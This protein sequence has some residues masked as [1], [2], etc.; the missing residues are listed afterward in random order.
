MIV[1]IRSNTSRANTSSR[2][3][4]RST[5]LPPPPR[6]AKFVKASNTRAAQSSNTASATARLPAATTSTPAAST[7]RTQ[8]PGRTLIGKAREQAT[9]IASTAADFISNVA[10][11]SVKTLKSSLKSLKNLKQYA[12]KGR[13]SVRTAISQNKL[14]GRVAGGLGIGIDAARIAASNDRTRTAIQVGAGRACGVV[15][16]IA[17]GAVGGAAGSLLAPGPGTALGVVSGATA[18]GLAASTACESVAGWAVDRFRANTQNQ[19]RAWHGPI[20]PRTLIR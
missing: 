7:Q 6:P 1:N 16:N 10:D 8:Q 2:T 11:Q 20:Q 9:T 15:G 17:G 12:V 4:T 18:G 3:S 13:K 14:I 5:P 19:P